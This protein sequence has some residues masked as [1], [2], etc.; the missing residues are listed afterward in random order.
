MEDFGKKVTR[1]RIQ[2]SERAVA[3]KTVGDAV[4]VFAIPQ[5]L[6]EGYFANLAKSQQRRLLALED[7]RREPAEQGV[8]DKYR[9]RKYCNLSIGEKVEIA[10]AAVIKYRFHRDIAEEFRVSTGLVG[11][12]VRMAKTGHFAKLVAEVEIFAN[13]GK[14]IGKTCK[15]LLETD[16]ALS[17]VASVRDR[18]QARLPHRISLKRVS[19]VMRDNLGLKF[20][21]AK[22]IAARTNCVSCLYQ[23][24]VFAKKLIDEMMTGKRVINIDEASLSEARFVRKAWGHRNLPLRPLKMPLGHRVSIIAAVDN[25]GASFFALVQGIIDSRVFATFLHH[26]VID[27]DGEDPDWR[28]NTLLVLDGASIHRSEEACRAMSALQI[29]AMIAGPYGF[30]GSP[31]E[32]LFALLKAGDLNPWEIPTG[33]K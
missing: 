28:E 15:R 6:D 14:M 21:K 18:V 30:D 12:I 16:G 33:K 5:Q 22:S 32:K 1:L 26:L 17:S 31:C 25:L 10:H 24:Q 19:R 20:K 3:I 4:D 8:S 2:V 29:P 7:A 27:L 11:R 13:V 9:R 23:R